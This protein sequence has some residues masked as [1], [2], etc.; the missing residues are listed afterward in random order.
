MLSGKRSR[1]W[2][3]AMDR[4]GALGAVHSRL[5]VDGQVTK[6][7]DGR[8]LL[9]NI[10][11]LVFQLCTPGY[12]DLPVGLTVLFKHAGKVIL[13]AGVP[14]ILRQSSTEYLSETP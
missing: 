10:L 5:R 3:P 9:S 12:A 8:Q 11:S 1:L 6:L 13:Q 7:I 14:H 2:T 4:V